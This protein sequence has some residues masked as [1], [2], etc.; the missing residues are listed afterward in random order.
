MRVSENEHRYLVIRLENLLS[1]FQVGRLRIE[2]RGH[3]V[4]RLST[5]ATQ[6]SHEVTFD[7]QRGDTEQ[8]QE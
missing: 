7:D 8:N 6:R 5:K 3:S 1:P 2:D 4:A